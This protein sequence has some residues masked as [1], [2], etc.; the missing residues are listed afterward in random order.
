MSTHVPGFQ[1]FFRLFR[2]F[3]IGQISHHHHKGYTIYSPK[4]MKTRTLEIYY[5]G[6]NITIPSGLDKQLHL[7]RKQFNKR[8]E[9]DLI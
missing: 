2:S 7:P 5:D 1:S 3:R 6:K 9:T 4:Q 8:K